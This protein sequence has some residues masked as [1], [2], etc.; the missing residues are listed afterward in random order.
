M[1]H[2][3]LIA[4]AR[5][6]NGTPFRVSPEVDGRNGEDGGRGGSGRRWDP[7][8]TN[9]NT[10]VYDND[11]AGRD[12]GKSA[13]EKVAGEEGKRQ[14]QRRWSRTRRESGKKL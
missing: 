14:D 10:S 2:R 13:E 9:D 3:R 11:A 5:K 12:V 8:I 7:G 6:A 4:G 1:L